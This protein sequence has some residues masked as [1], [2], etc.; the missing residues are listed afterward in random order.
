MTPPPIP[1]QSPFSNTKIPLNPQ[2]QK[3]SITEF[4]PVPEELPPPLPN[5]QV[6]KLGLQHTATSPG[7]KVRLVIKYVPKMTIFKLHGHKKDNH[8]NF[9]KLLSS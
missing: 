5:N 1:R 4:P 3:S 7:P 8:Q 2:I 6:R 9:I